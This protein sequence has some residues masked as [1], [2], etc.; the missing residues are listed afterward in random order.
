[1]LEPYQILT[2]GSGSILQVLKEPGI[3]GKLEIDILRFCPELES[4]TGPKLIALQQTRYSKK[5]SSLSKFVVTHQLGPKSQV[6]SVPRSLMSVYDYGHCNLDELSSEPDDV[7]VDKTMSSLA[8]AFETKL[9]QYFV[10][11][12][13]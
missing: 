4:E 2:P 3:N 7:V 9:G 12:T 8:H 6:V 1:V 11:K 13:L 10:A 5:L